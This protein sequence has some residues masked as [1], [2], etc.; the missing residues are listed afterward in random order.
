MA[1]IIGSIANGPE[2]AQKGLTPNET[3]FPLKE[4]LILSNEEQNESPPAETSYL[5]AFSDNEQGESSTIQSKKDYVE[6]NYEQYK[7]RDAAK[8]SEELD[9]LAES[10]SRPLVWEKEKSKN[11]TRDQIAKKKLNTLV[12]TY[13]KIRK[14]KEMGIKNERPKKFSPYDRM[15]EIF[16]HRPIEECIILKNTSEF[17]KRI[18]QNIDSMDDYEQTNSSK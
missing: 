14:C 9:V 10:L 11:L 2:S 6:A 12:D 1:T 15:H 13:S 7:L 5:S 16:S 17:K 3:Q 18:F 8:S 4:N